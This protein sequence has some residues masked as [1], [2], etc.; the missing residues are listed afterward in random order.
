M[1]CV[2][3]RSSCF[4]APRPAETDAIRYIRGTRLDG[5]GAG[6]LTGLPSSTSTCPMRRLDELPVSSK[7]YCEEGLGFDAGDKAQTVRLRQDGMRRTFASG[8]GS[9]LFP[10]PTRF[11]PV[12]RDSCASREAAKR[13]C[14]SCRDN[15]L[16][17]RLERQGLWNAEELQTLAR[18]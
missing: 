8:L 6:D 16:Q 17:G 15:K 11:G 5:G 4:W 9:S 7:I 10:P 1:E 18:L 3:A 13:I 2:H 14:R 12:R